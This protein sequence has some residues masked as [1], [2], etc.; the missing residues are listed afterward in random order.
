MNHENINKVID[1]LNRGAPEVIFSMR[2]ALRHIDDTAV[3]DKSYPEESDGYYSLAHSQRAKVDNNSCGSVCC[4]AGAAAQFDGVKIDDPNYD[5][6]TPIQDRAL[7]YFGIT[8]P[9]GCPW[10]LPVFDP[11]EA[12]QNCGPLT[13]AKALKRWADHVAKHPDH[14]TFNPWENME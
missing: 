1:W 9:E 6:W 11:D 13:A 3:A 5:S 2:Y 4:I 7:R 8:K 10:M 12:P 14:I